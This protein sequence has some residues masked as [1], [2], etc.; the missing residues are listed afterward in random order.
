MKNEIIEVGDIMSI[1]RYRAMNDY[2]FEAFKNNS[3]NGS[4][5]RCF[6]EGIELNYRISE[7][8]ISRYEISN[9]ERHKVI[10]ILQNNIKDKYYLACFTKVSP[11]NNKKMWFEFADNGNGYCL[12][13]Y[14]EDIL[15]AIRQQEKYRVTLKMVKY[16]SEPYCLDNII[17]F[18]CSYDGVRKEIEENN[19]E[20]ALSKTN[21][22]IRKQV[23]DTLL[24]KYDKH[25]GEKEVRLIMQSIPE[26]GMKNDDFNPCIIR[27]KPRRVFISRGVNVIDMYRI[28]YYANK[29]GILI[30]VIENPCK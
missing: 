15:T 23:M 16:S 19:V 17:D 22:S 5:F 7:D 12:E 29:N 6:D 24:Y 4:L 14:E 26:G 9:D 20:V 3:I 21:N 2:N 30:E 8:I 18:I 10:D 25:K 13:Y 28:I 11:K 27:V 1:F